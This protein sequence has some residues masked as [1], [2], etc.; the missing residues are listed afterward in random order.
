MIQS[1]LDEALLV[2]KNNHEG[3]HAAYIPELANVPPELTAG[4]IMMSDGHRFVAGD[5]VDYVF[6]LQSV[7]WSSLSSMPKKKD[8]KRNFFPHRFDCC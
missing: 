2:A 7:S 5:A 3:S 1:V 6:S 8:Q 4:A